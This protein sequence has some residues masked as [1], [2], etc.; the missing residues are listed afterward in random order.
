MSVLKI[1]YYLIVL[2][3][4]VACSNS[5]S[6]NNNETNKKTNYDQEI[7]EIIQSFPSPYSF[8]YCLVKTENYND[9]LFLN[10]TNYNNIDS[11]Y[12]AIALGIAIAD[13]SFKYYHYKNIDLELKMIRKL[14]T[15]LDLNKY[16]EL[17][18]FKFH[19]NND[20][21]NKLPQNIDSLLFLSAKGIENYIE[22]N[23]S[24]NKY[25]EI[26]S[27]LFGFWLKNTYVLLYQSEKE[28]IVDIIGAEKLVV[29]EFWQIRTLLNDE[30]LERQIENLKIAFDKGSLHVIQPMPIITV[31]GDSVII[32]DATEIYYEITDSD[33]NNIKKEITNTYNS[34]LLDIRTD[35]NISLLFYPFVSLDATKHNK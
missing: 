18:D 33:F 10:N 34:I 14:S 17:K 27:I 1:K 26:I 30:K 31:I 2:L 11:Q 24:Q 25:D 7:R 29:K 13:L 15:K 22:N 21:A 8:N 35:Y 5:T 3:L 32:D 9:T 12:V 4:S 16:F 20:I 28:D 23:N 6:N 19:K